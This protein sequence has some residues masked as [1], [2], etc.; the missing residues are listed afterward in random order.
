MLSQT[1]YRLAR[2]HPIILT[3]ILMAG[4]VVQMGAAGMDLSPL[5]RGVLL[6]TPLA[7]MC[8]WLWAVFHVSKPG[9]EA[10]VSDQRGWI[11][12]MPPSVAFVAGVAGWSTNNSPAAFAVFLSLFVG[13]FWAART[14]ENVDAPTGSATVGRILA[15]VILMYLAPLG[16]WVLR[17]KI[18]RVAA[19]SQGSHP[20]S[21]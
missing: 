14:L 18:L 1:A 3:T 2:W 12:A 4:L 6:L 19:R 20:S 17:P 9:P 10:P 21:D 16:A 5:A 15:T 8:V 11:F 7:P 13:I